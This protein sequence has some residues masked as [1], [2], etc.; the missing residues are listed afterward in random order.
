MNSDDL[1]LFLAIWGAALSTFLGFLKVRDYFRDR[2]ILKIS[3]KPGYKATKGSPYGDMALLMITVANVGRRPIFINGVSL[4]VPRSKTYL[5]CGDPHSARYPVEL[6]EGQA[7]NFIMNEDEIR[8]KYGVRDGEFV[9][10][11]NDA[12]GREYWSDNPIT[13]LWKIRR[14]K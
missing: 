11:A 13:R 6:K 8:Q 5:L 2:P 1:T 14:W 4:V 12:P 7:H 3:V 9:A 10:M